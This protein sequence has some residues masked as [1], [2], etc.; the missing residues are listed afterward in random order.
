M[1][2]SSWKSSALVSDFQEPE[3]LKFSEFQKI[4]KLVKKSYKIPGTFHLKS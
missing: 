2:S 3:S 1:Y 4:I